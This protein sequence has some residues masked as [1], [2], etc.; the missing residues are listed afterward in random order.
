MT[1]KFALISPSFRGDFERCKLLLES[2]VN[3]VEPKVNYYLIV[4]SS[5][6]E[7]FNTL[8]SIYPVTVIPEETLLPWYIFKTPFSKKWRLNLFGLP[9]R[10]WMI[11]QICK[12]NITKVVEEDIYVILDSDICFVNKLDLTSFEKD[13]KVRLLSFSGKANS[14][15]HHP[16]HRLAGKLLGLEPKDYFGSGYIG[17]VVTWRKDTLVK[18]HQ[19]LRKQNGRF[20]L[21]KILNQITV[22]EYILYGV[23]CEFILKENSGHFKEE[24]NLAKEY[25]TPKSLTDEQL[26]EFFDTFDHDTQQAIMITAKAGIPIERYRHHIEAKWKALQ[27]DT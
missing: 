12:L 3:C 11:Q 7:L 27:Q 4:P 9:I 23:F 6:V 22:S 24:H 14:P 20:W 21:L 25:W 10:G 17:N 15:S 1:N 5:D 2:I 16:W 19:H 26:S 13:D 18:L 8:Q